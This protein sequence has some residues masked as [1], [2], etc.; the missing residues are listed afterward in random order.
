MSVNDILLLKQ[1]IVVDSGDWIP[2]SE[3]NIS[4]FLLQEYDF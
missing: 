3:N 4:A 2:I 1:M